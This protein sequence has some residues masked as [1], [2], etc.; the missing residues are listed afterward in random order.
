M[1]LIVSLLRAALLTGRFVFAR[2][3]LLL[4]ARVLF[5]RGTLIVL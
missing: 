2:L 3:V 1:F 5:L 4:L